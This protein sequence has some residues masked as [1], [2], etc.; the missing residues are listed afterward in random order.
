MAAK[1][2]K[3]RKTASVQWTGVYDLTEQEKIQLGLVKK[4]KTLEDLVHIVIPVHHNSHG[5]IWESRF[6]TP[7]AVDLWRAQYPNMEVIG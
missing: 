6:V 7:A 1:G 2:E 4:P 5:I 3:W